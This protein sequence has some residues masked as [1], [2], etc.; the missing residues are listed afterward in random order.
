[1]AQKSKANKIRGY[2]LSKGKRKYRN[3][4]TA[5]KSFAGGATKVGGAVAGGAAAVGGAARAA[6]DDF[7][8]WIGEHPQWTFWIFVFILAIV[9]ITMLFAYDG[10]HKASNFRFEDNDENISDLEDNDNNDNEEGS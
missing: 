4:L 8:K 2:K 10:K 3:V 9:I 1:M 6:K 5:A 7:F